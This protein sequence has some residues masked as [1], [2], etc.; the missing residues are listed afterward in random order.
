MALISANLGLMN[1]LPIPV[2][3]GG[4]LLFFIIEIIAR[5]PIPEKIQE[6]LLQGGFGILILVMV[7]AT[8]NDFKSILF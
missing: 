5:R 3:D 6:K 1:L 7:F 2:L 8:F 4:H